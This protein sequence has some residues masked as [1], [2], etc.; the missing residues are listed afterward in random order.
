[1]YK[2]AIKPKSFGKLSKFFSAH[3]W[4]ILYSDFICSFNLRNFNVFVHTFV[5]LH[6]RP[7][8]C[9]TGLVY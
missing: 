6:N 9:A 2:M 5:S 4:K 3:V 7:P 8:V 1:V